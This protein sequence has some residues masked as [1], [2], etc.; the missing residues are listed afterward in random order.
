MTLGLVRSCCLAA[1]IGG[2]TCLPGVAHADDC[3]AAGSPA[4]GQQE[5]K[6][7]D[8]GQS[9]TAACACGKA[10]GS[11]D[12]CGQH[13]KSAPTPATLQVGQAAPAFTLKS[14]DDADVSLADFK[15]KWV[16]VYFYPKAATSGCTL[17]ACDLSEKIAE[18]SGMDAVILGISPDAVAALKK[19]Q[20]DEQ[21]KIT[22]LSDPDKNAMRAYK[23]WQETENDGKKSA[24]LVRSTVVIDPD[25]VAV[26]HWPSVSP[27]GHADMVKAKLT[28]LREARAKAAAEKQA[29]DHA[30]AAGHG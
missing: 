2:L 8:Q 4:A 20:E 3:C 15:G 12:D 14:Q 24:R 1:L 16:V 5:S 17:Q 26:H 6:N 9:K 19:F 27:R 29:A 22:L 25:G 11:C 7:K 10:E 28:E 18:F 21:L 23:A 30:A 13:A